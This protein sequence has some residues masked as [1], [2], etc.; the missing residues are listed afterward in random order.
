MKTLN[1]LRDLIKNQSFALVKLWRVDVIK[2]IAEIENLETKL[3]AEQ[4]RTQIFMERF[5]SAQSIINR[6]DAVVP[7]YG[8]G[9]Q[10]THDVVEWIETSKLIRQEHINLSAALSESLREVSEL[11]ARHFLMRSENRENFRDSPVRGNNYDANLWEMRHLRAIIADGNFLVAIHED[12]GIGYE[13]L[14]VRV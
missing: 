13:V 11:K 10:K 5:N 14:H 4:V 8:R 7:V 6:I 1:K 9:E 12:D 2:L 3:K